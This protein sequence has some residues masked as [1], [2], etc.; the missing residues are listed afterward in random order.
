M[1]L[2]CCEE[3]HYLFSCNSWTNV[4]TESTSRRYGFLQAWCV[5]PS[6]ISTLFQLGL[7]EIS[8]F[9]LFYLVS[10]LKVFLFFFHL[11]AISFRGQRGLSFSFL[12]LCNQSPRSLSQARENW[13]QEGHLYGVSL[14]RIAMKACAI[15]DVQECRPRPVWNELRLQDAVRTR[16]AQKSKERKSWLRQFEC[17]Q[18]RG[19]DYIRMKLMNWEII[20]KDENGKAETEM[21]WYS[22]RQSISERSDGGYRKPWPGWGGEEE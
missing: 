8:L 20:V 13:R 3:F 2:N 19:E 15:S 17:V 11:D 4:V 22:D 18:Q 6:L 21:E 16:S 12:F 7:I 9:N 5:L 10:I 1:W 14:N